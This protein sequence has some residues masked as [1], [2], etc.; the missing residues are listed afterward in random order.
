MTEKLKGYI[1]LEGRWYH[2][3][4][5]EAVEQ[6]NLQGEVEVIFAFKRSKKSKEV[7]FAPRERFHKNKPKAETKRKKEEEN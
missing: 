2:L 5:V 6:L 4:L 1:Q 7:E 3:T